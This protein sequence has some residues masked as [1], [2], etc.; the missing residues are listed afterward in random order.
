M[1]GRALE[2]G[3]GDPAA[4]DADPES[5]RRETVQL[6]CLPGVK[7]KW[8]HARQLARR[9]AGENLPPWRCT[10]YMAAEVLSA[11]G[12]EVESEV[13]ERGRAEAAAAI[14]P[15][16]EAVGG[17][18]RGEPGASCAVSSPPGLDSAARVTP[19]WQRPAAGEAVAP[20]EPVA[21]P[22]RDAEAPSA[23]A[24]PRAEEATSVSPSL[25]SLPAAAA[26]LA[27]LVAD[28]ASADAFELD[29][30]LRRALRL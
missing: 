28:L 7:G 30:R 23:Y 20:G 10:E 21:P 6:R 2:N 26:F 15:G 17:V 11:L 8:F 24:E 19:L 12:L 16:G 14:H 3:G 13:E 22:L 25:S 18:S 5:W 29:E 9:V 1:D 27:P 4:D